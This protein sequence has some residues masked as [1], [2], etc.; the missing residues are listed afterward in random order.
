MNRKPLWFA[1]AAVLAL[2]LSVVTACDDDGAGPGDVDPGQTAAVVDAT[3]DQFLEGND[4]IQS[5]GVFNEAMASALGGVAPSVLVWDMVPGS[6]SPFASASRI[7]ASVSELTEG[8]PLNIPV[9][10]LGVTFIFDPVDGYVPSQRTGAPANGVRFILYAVDPI[11]EEP[12]TPLQ[13]IGWFDIIDTSN[14]ST[15]T[16]DI[17]LEAVVG[18]VTL[19]D[20]TSTGVL[21]QTSLTLD[22]DG[23]LSDGQN[24]LNFTIDALFSETA[25]DFTFGMTAD[26]V[27]VSVV[28]SGSD[29]GGAS[30]TTTFS[31]GDNSIVVTLSVDASDN[32]LSGSGV[33]FNGTTVAVI[34]D[35][36]ENPTI[37]NAEGDPLTAEELAAVEDLFIAMVDV[38][39]FGFGVFEFAL[40]L[41]LLGLV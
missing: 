41:I 40:F 21:T 1:Q 35:T 15:G 12:V 39:E 26:G 34:S 28:F 9:G 22:F 11:L 37:T 29:T 8:E 14:F 6:T 3:V 2:A 31:D 32:I 38:V 17:S 19:V 16:I 13:E 30:I 24:S 7:Q 25:F 10:A 23:T 5:I 33:S 4:A 18:G 27:G 36:I 20:V